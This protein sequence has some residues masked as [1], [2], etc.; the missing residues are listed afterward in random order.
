[1]LERLA[2]EVRGDAPESLDPDR[3]MLLADAVAGL[4][5]T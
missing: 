5:G 1:M 3:M 4:A 2:E